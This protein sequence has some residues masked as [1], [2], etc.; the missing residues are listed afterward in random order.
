VSTGQTPDLRADAFYQ[1]PWPVYAWLREH[2][3]VHWS[4]QF[5][6]WIVTRFDDVMA[7]MRDPD[8][9]SNAGRQL[10]LLERLPADAQDRL[11]PIKEFYRQ[12]GLIN[13][14]PPAHTRLR[15]LVQR[16]FT[17]SAVERIR[18]RVQAMV[19]AL[20]DRHLATG[21]MELI[22]DL[23]KPL[24]SQVIAAMLGAPEKDR[25]QFGGWADQISR[26]LG[27]QPL[28]V[29]IALQAQDAIVQMRDYFRGLLQ[30]RRHN[31]QQDV[32]TAMAEA[33]ETGDVLTEQQILASCQNLLIAG[34]DTTQQLIAN[35][36]AMLLAHPDQLQAVL[37]NPT[38]V[39]A[40]IEETLCFE[41]SAHIIRRR[42]RWDVELRGK[43]IR[44]GQP[45][46]MG[47]G[48]ANHDPALFDRPDEFDTRRPAEPNR[49]IAFGYGIHYCIGAPLAW[50]EGEVAVATVLR[51]LP[52]LRLADGA[53]LRWKNV[54]VERALEQLPVAFT[55]SKV[56]S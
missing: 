36:I 5:G 19:D 12:G 18:P 27:A 45:V 30:Q 8:R 16:A 21:C 34:Q 32:L 23:A 3:P 42:A 13:S 6:A 28:T 35:T 47:V 4:E 51:R 22:R 48:A 40:A 20:I 25:P 1:N 24:P 50:L 33:D 17:L 26:Y 29:E 43:S 2:D 7:I 10:E 56:K 41:G 37:A 31:R 15:R 52:G 38:L 49:H 44:A 53:T 46:I 11:G 39:Q 54:I 55:P 14:D 9:F